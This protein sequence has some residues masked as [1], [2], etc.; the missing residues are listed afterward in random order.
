MCMSHTRFYLCE[1]DCIRGTLVV[2][3]SI[4]GNLSVMSRSSDFWE[5]IDNRWC[6]LLTVSVGLIPCFS[7]TPIL[8]GKSSSK[9]AAY[10]RAVTVC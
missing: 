9:S 8:E 5:S 6:S 7:S 10:T 3:S 1:S 4:Y 2:A